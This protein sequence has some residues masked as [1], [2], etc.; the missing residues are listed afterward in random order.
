MIV[1]S[2]ADKVLILFAPRLSSDMTLN[3]P[4]Q[5]AVPRGAFRFVEEVSAQNEPIWLHGADGQRL[6]CLVE[7][8]WLRLWQRPAGTWP[9]DR[10]HHNGW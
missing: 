8:V 7:F 3:R 9:G 1:R 5:N 10:N 2:I 4:W 6:G